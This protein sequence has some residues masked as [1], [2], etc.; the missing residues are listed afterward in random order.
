[1]SVAKK[2]R[3]IGAVLLIL[4]L[5]GT[6][7]AFHTYQRLLSGTTEDP[8]APPISI[9]IPE[10]A[11][12]YQIADYL[13]ENGLVPSRWLFLLAARIKGV[14]GSL[15]YGKY[16]LSPSMS[17]FE[18]LDALREGTQEGHLI[19]IP[20]G[21]TVA[22]T[23]RLLVQDGSID[24]QSFLEAA[25]DPDLAAELGL[26]VG[27][28]PDLLFL[29]EGFLFP[30]TYQIT[31]GMTGSD[32]VRIMAGRFSEVWAE[33]SGDQTFPP[34]EVFD[35]VNVA[36]IA[37][38]EAVVPEERPLIA[39]VVFNRLKK[40]MRIDCDATIAYGL[41]K[42][43]MRLRTADLKSDTPYN[44]RIYAGLPPGPI[45]NPGRAALQAAL[46][47]QETDFLYYVSRNDG[48]HQFSKTLREHNR[49][50]NKYQRNRQ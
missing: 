29:M 40:G 20:E 47:P 45:G 18:I 48:T 25:N 37:E 8:S 46:S 5:L 11:S 9:E 15:K 4:V 39:G 42:L 32:L 28:N 23:A 43:G 24:S 30:D 7:A 19:T 6:V 27:E 10:G 22:Q 41:N 21:Y 35:L 31:E 2:L 13:E 12:A 34:E 33:V 16:E 44:S 38:Q 50:V 14:E 3:R 1:M 49:A 26:P 36:S 17:S